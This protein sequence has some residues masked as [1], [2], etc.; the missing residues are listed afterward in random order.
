MSVV[1]R[2][3]DV[4]M[5]C[6]SLA[7][8]HLDHVNAVCICQVGNVKAEATWCWAMFSPRQP[9]GPPAGL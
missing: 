7:H 3:R 8:S 6:C 2:L 5:T 4:K 1:Q 9:Q